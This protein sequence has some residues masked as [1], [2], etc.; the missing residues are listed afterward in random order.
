M[1]EFR[2]AAFDLGGVTV[3]I[4]TTWAAALGAAG[5]ERRDDLGGLSAFDA[6]DHYALGRCD[7]DA[8]LPELGRHTGLDVARA[9]RAHMAVLRDEYEGVARLMSEL[10]TS[11]VVVGCLSDTNALH[12]ERLTDPST[13]S[14]AQH[15]SVRVASHLVGACKPS[16]A[17]YEAFEAASGCSGPEVVYFED[18]PHN[19][20]AALQRGWQACLINP[21]G[22]PEAQMR[23]F[24]GGP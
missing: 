24:L 9:T 12:F 1:R 14:F 11:G 19:V 16:A 21:E 18:G 3:K 10:A 7:A 23:A 22:D 17:M 8:Y 2:A 13:Y 5:F 4:H 20:E 15:L 6:F